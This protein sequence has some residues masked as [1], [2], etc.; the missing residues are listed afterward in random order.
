MHTSTAGGSSRNF[1]VFIHRFWS[2]TTA[3]NLPVLSKTVTWTSPRSTANSWASTTT[4]TL[5]SRTPPRATS[6]PATVARSRSRNAPA[7]RF[8]SRPPTWAGQSLQKAF[9]TY[10]C[11]SS[12]TGLSSTR[13]Q[14]PKTVPLTLRVSVP[15]AKFMMSAE[16]NTFAITSLRSSVPLKMAQRFARTLVGRSWT[17][18]NGPRVTPSV[19]A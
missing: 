12:V 4:P 11:A 9:T 18:S 8:H 7:A 6:L 10:S 16:S 13:S 17:T 1:T 5:S 19:L 14:S 2:T 3:T 15:T